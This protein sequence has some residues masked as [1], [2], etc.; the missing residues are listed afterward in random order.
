MSEE[1]GRSPSRPETPE[2]AQRLPRRRALRLLGGVLGAA[3]GLGG[4]ISGCGGG[5]ERSGAGADRVPDSVSVP[6]ERLAGG[7]RVRVTVGGE[8]V[9]VRRDGERIIARS[10]LCTHFGCVVAWNAEQQRYVC[11]CHDGIYAP[12]GRVVGGPPSRPLP[13]LPV[14]RVDGAV[15]VHAPGGAGG[16]EGA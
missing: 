7:E 8:P 13:E 10:L 12:D 3:V 5:E 15:I 6:L 4:S 14:E 9:E 2:G 1:R 16:G 11:P